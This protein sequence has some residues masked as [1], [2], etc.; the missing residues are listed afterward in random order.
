MQAATEKPR[1]QHPFA[2]KPGS[3]L[4]GM[5]Q[6]TVFSP[7]SLSPTPGWQPSADR[8][9]RSGLISPGSGSTMQTV[10]RY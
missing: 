2:G 7:A 6:E 5:L 9:Q 4:P 8:R 3:S 10:P 1:L